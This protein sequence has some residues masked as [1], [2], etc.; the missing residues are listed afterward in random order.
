[1]L[2]HLACLFHLGPGA[3]L[4]HEGLNEHT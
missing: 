4:E 1:L 2:H 3:K